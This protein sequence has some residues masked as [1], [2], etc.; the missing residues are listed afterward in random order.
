VEVVVAGGT[1][2]V[3]RALVASLERDG[4]RSVVVSREPG[5]GRVSWDGVLGAVD[6]ADAVVNFAGASIGRPRWT[7][8]RKRTL[9]A[10][11]VETTRK[12]AEAIAAAGR[13]PR[14]FVTA[15]GIDY[16]G[17][18]G[19]A[20]VDESSP[21]GSTFLARLCAEWEAVAAAAPV[22]H[23]AVRTAL[24]VARDAPAL[25][26]TALPFRLFAGGTLGGGEQWFPW[27]HL[28][29]LVAVY[30]RALEDDALAGPVDAV[31]PQQLRQREA[32]R[33]LG[34]V[35]HRPA[36]L[37]TPA[38][39]LRLLLGEQA[40]LLLHGQRAGSTK[41]TPDDFA[42]RELRPALEQALA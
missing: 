13:K 40:D 11:R 34:A 28:D 41:L 9:R 8:S 5:P 12:L 24:V 33:E 30:R 15:S 19:D 27:V 42:Y 26:L 16:Y 38:V 29:D 39:A 4:H 31:A 20:V 23:V 3:G 32:A 22:R 1:G 35:L 7:E 14:V 17:D 18:S 6:G 21:P 25:R 37:S 36:V 10:S 2:L